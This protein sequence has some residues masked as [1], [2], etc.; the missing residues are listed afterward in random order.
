[1]DTESMKLTALQCRWCGRVIAGLHA[2]LK[3]ECGDSVECHEC[4]NE[5]Y[6]ELVR[7]EE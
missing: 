7:V 4:G 3:Y 2:I 6:F 5:E 1:M